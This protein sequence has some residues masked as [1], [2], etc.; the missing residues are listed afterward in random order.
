M[1]PDEPYPLGQD[2]AWLA[3]DAAG[4]VAIFTNAGQGPIPIAVLADR[5][6]S[7]QAESMIEA[8]P[9]RGDSHMLVALPSPDAF[10][11][12][13]RRGLFAY[14]WQDCHRNTGR[15]HRYELLAR[16]AVPVTV[17]ELAGE[18]A[19]LIGRVRFQSLRF[20]DSLA[21]AV[22]DQVESRRA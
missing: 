19:A 11:A 14:D 1:E 20:A 18:V 5:Q 2:Y 8:L 4:H 7:D 6:D 21:I 16:P 10:V 13:A 22:D 9:E 15:P 12:F 3:T 17:E